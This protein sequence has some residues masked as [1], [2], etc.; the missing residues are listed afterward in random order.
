MITSYA[1]VSMCLRKLMAPQ[2]DPSTT[3]VGL[4][5]GDSSTRIGLWKE[6]G[7]VTGLFS[8]DIDDVTV[9]DAARETLP[10][11]DKMG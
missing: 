7:P 5:V 8:G 2:P 4:D 10:L 6:K 9:V 3:T 1:L 11:S